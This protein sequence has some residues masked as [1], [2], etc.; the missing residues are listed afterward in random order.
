[1]AIKTWNFFFLVMLFMYLKITVAA[2]TI[3][4]ERFE[5]WDHPVLSVFKKYGISLYKISY[6]K[7]RTCPTFYAKFKY[8][9]DPRAPASYI[10][11]NKIYAEILHANSS[12]PYALVDEA[13]NFKI[14]IG[15]E[16]RSKT[17]IMIRLNRLS[18]SSACKDGSGNPD[19]ENFQVTSELKERILNSPFKV[20]LR[21]NNGK[22]VIAY[23][24]AEDERNK[25][26][27]HTSCATGKK[28]KIVA[29]V[30]HYYIYL[31]D[32]STNSFYPS[33]IAVFDYNDPIYLNIEE[34]DFLVLKSPDKRKSN[35][36]LIGKSDNCKESFY[37][38]YGFWKDQPSL[39]A[40]TFN[41]DQEYVRLSGRI[42][43]NKLH[44]GNLIMDIT[45]D[46]KTRKY[47]LSLSEKPGEIELTPF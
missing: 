34:T 4:V 20:S 31:Y 19:D 23:L 10:Y 15:F 3:Q 2:E 27:K 7:D 44:D 8:S 47:A 43:R 38:V 13:D 24:Y 46:K 33:R 21:Q 45:D 25:F 28:S 42:E 5:K 14:N 9:P 41:H 35:A 36:L 32:K 18:S 40:Y 29:Q 26:I 17:I 16:D 6:S 22:K 12:F 30:G 1:M 37:E 11:Y 39:Q